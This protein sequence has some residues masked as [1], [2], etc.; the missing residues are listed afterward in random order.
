MKTLAV[1]NCR[2]HKISEIFTGGIHP[3]GKVNGAQFL[4]THK[5]VQSIPPT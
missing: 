5:H 4:S 3:C 2:N 1:L